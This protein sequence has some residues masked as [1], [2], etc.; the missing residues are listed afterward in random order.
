LGSGSK[1]FLIN[2]DS[3]KQVTELYEDNNFYTVP[4]FIKPDTTTPT[5]NITFDGYDIIDGDCISDKPLIKTELSDLSLLPITDPS[6]VEIYLN[7][8]LIPPD[9]SIL[10]YQFSETNPKVIVEFTPDLADGEY[11]LR[12]LGKNASGNLADSAGVERFFLVSN[13]AKILY[14][15]N[16]PNP[17]KDATSFTF[18]LTQIPDEIKIKIFTIAGRLVKEMKLSS[19]QL[20]FDF[21]KIYWDGKDEDGDQLANGVYL[22]KVIMRAGDKTEAVTQKLAIVR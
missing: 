16:Y 20:N 14:V 3:D 4:F 2:I 8:V 10:N 7:E 19:S 5:M 17:F 1:T 12:V 13:E 18:K 15:Y 11:S 21:N 6:A 22:Y 9:T